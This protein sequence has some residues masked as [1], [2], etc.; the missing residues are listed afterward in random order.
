MGIE[1]YFGKWYNIIDISLLNALLLKLNKL[2]KTKTIYPKQTNVF[3]AFKLCDYDNCSLVFIG[4]DPYPNKKATGILFGNSNTLDYKDWSPSLKIV[5]DSLLSNNVFYKSINFDSTLESWAKQ[6]IL[7]LNS[8]LT[9]EANN[10]GSHSLMWRPFMSKFLYNLSINN[11]SLIYVLFGNVAQKY[12]NNIIKSNY[13]F[14]VKH[15]SYYAKTNT[16]MP[17]I[18]IDINEKLKQINGN[19]ISWYGE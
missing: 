3:K 7:M 14:N 6:G 9:V 19:T 15:P 5:K 11:P 10:I 16:L 12:V 8:A 2:Y 4:L 13:I 17:N 1:E 18:F